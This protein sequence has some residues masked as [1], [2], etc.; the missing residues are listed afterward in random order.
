MANMELRKL[1][2]MNDVPQ[3]KIAERL[4][5][6]EMTLYRWMRKELSADL[7]EKIRAAILEIAEGA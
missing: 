4:R 1:A 2:R 5:V 7:S 3:W 6:S